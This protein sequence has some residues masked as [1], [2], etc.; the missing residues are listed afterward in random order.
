M[1]GRRELIGYAVV[2]RNDPRYLGL[3]VHLGLEHRGGEMRW[4]G[5]PDD[6]HV[7]SELD[8]AI[9]WRAEVA[10]ALLEGHLPPEVVG[11][12]QTRKLEFG[13]VIAEKPCP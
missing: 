1:S 6:P 7:F 5:P 2:S 4:L 10:G 3:D 12:Y 11:V 13:G 8:D 9:R